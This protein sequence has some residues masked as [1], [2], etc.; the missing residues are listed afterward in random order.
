MNYTR[1]PAVADDPPFDGQG[2][3]HQVPHVEVQPDPMH[4]YERWADRPRPTGGAIDPEVGA[5][6]NRV[7]PSVNPISS[8]SE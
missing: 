7:H 8:M 5:I 3:D 6:G 2:I 1:G 4:H